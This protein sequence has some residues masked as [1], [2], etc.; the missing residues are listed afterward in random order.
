V[1]PTSEVAGVQEVGPVWVLSSGSVASRG[2]GRADGLGQRHSSVR[3]SLPRWLRGMRNGTRFLAVHLPS[4]N[5]PGLC[6]AE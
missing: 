3:D 1:M 5:R 2:S 6:V 4:N